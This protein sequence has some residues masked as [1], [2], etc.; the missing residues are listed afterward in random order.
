[1]GSDLSKEMEVPKFSLTS[2]R[3]NMSTFLG[4]TLHFYSINDPRTLLNTSSDVKAAEK[5]VQQ[6]ER[7]E[8]PVGTT[9]EDLWSARRVLESALHPDT[10]QP[11]LPLFRFSAFVPVN[12]A[13]VTLT[14][15][16]AVLKSFPATAGI[17]FLN[18]TYNAAINYANRNA[19]NPVPTSR[20]AEGYAGAVATSLSIGMSATYLTKKIAAQGGGGVAAS[21]VRTTLPFLAVAGAGASNVFLMRRNELEE[22]VDMF[23]DAGNVLGKSVEAGKVGLAKCAAARVIWNI[24]VMVF[25]PLI[26]TRLE[27]LPLLAGNPRLRLACETAVVTGCL[28]GAV[29]PALAFFPQRDSLPTEKLEAQFQGL[30]GKDGRPVTRLWYNKGL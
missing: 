28:L 6:Y 29:S 12:M 10:K 19:S 13:V 15:T 2:P 17:H 25:P 3:Y 21:V 26:M 11:I 8:C 5:L 27:K 20:L 24:P 23:D 22:G 14:L 18:Q 7:G 1:M 4:R 30:V 16:P 9:D